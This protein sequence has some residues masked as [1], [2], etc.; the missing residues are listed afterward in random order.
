MRSNL[1]GHDS[2]SFGS[3][4]VIIISHSRT[5]T[6]TKF[7]AAKQ[8]NKHLVIGERGGEKLYDNR[9]Y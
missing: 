7:F 1:S 2:P 6:A 8:V 5:M 4:R 9:I 3:P